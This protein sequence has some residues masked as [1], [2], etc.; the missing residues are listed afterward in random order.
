MERVCIF[1]DSG[2]FYHLVLK[3]LGI[4]ELDFNFDRF[5]KFLAGERE[6]IKEGKRFYV[7]TVRERKNRHENKRAISNQTTLFTSLFK[8]NWAIKTSKLRTRIEKIV[9]D[10]RVIDYQKF[11]DLGIEEIKYERSRE[12]GID[13]KLATD[14]IIGAMDD[15]YDNAILISSDTDLVPA[16]D[17]VRYRFKKKV[18]YIGFSILGNENYEFT[19]PTKR[20][21]YSTDIQ[22]VLAREDIK[23]FMMKNKLKFYQ[24][25]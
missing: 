23:P 8:L 1:I 14:L 15:K 10:D 11:L 25:D 24:E 18:E 12:K 7:G 4:Q 21:I 13:V 9:V 17:L 2:N 3:K 6:I 20:M 5:A 22:R 16:V 19:R